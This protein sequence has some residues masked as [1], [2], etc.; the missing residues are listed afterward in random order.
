LVP[1]KAKELI[2]PTA[3][4]TGSK[5]NLVE[6]FTSFYWSQIRSTLITGKHHNIFVENIGTFAVKPGKLKDIIKKHEDILRHMEPSSFRKCEIIHE[7]K[8][9]LEVLKK[10]QK[11]V[12][13]DIL[14][15]QNV[16][17]K[18]YGKET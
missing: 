12:D 1:K 2:R 5:K 8:R 13:E 18:K 7:V 16:T 10:L 6:D 15:K 11:S 17:N 3:E 4:I 14:K 9:R